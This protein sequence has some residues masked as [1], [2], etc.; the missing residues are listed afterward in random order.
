VRVE[1]GASRI[2][3]ENPSLPAG[4]S[5]LRIHGLPMRDGEVDISV[6]RRRGGVEVNALQAT[7]AVDVLVS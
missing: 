1:G 5:E 4:L 6:E 7:Q 3:F 2:L